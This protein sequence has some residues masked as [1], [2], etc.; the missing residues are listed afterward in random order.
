VTVQPAPRLFG[1]T[2]EL[3][4]LRRLIANVRSG[5]SAVLVVRGEPGIG[6]TALLQEL[7]GEASGFRVVRA[8]G[9]ESEMELAYAGLHQLCAPLLGGLDRLPVPQHDA[10]QTAF[11]ISAGPPPDRFVVALAALSLMEAASEEQP[12]LCVVDDAQ[13]LD[14]ASALVLGF[15]GRRLLAESIGLVFAA[16]TPVPSPDHLAGLPELRVGGLDDKPAR[17]LLATVTSA[18]LDDSVRARVIEETHG[19]P[20]ALLELYRGLRPAELA[21]GFALPDTGDLPQRIEDQYAARLGE[22]ADEVQRLV[23]LAAADPV[24]DLALILRA[25]QKLGLDIGAMNLAAAAG[26]LEVGAYVR[27]RHPLVRSAAYRAAGVKDRRAVHEALAAATDPQADPDRRPGTVRTRRLSL[28][29][30]WPGS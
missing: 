12:L 21:G 4:T 1:R 15:V 23:L 8:V 30:R 24:G 14:Q 6:K 29:R 3:G 26:L 19:N 2:G 7:I 5:Q 25:A 11:A 18:P 13:W 27:F 22:L 10:L 28:T 17:A 20:L 16:R 9:V